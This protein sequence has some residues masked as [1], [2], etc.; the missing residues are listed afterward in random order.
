MRWCFALAY[1]CAAMV[2]GMPAAADEPNLERGLAITDTDVLERLERRGLALDVFLKSDWQNGVEVVPASNAVLANMA[3]LKHVFAAVRREIL[4]TKNA[5]P[6]SGVGMSFDHKRLFDSGYLAAADARFPL[7]GIVQ[8]LD[9]TYKQP[10]TCGEVRLIYRLEYMRQTTQGL[11]RSRLPM[12]FNLVMKA[13]GTEDQISCSSL[14]K[15]WLAAGDKTTRGKALADYLLSSEGP[16]SLV[17]PRLIDRIETNFQ[18]LRRPATSVSQFGGHAEYVLKVFDWYPDS[19]HFRE[20]AM[21]NMIDRDRLIADPALLAAFKSWLLTP[22]KMREL[23][24]RNNRHSARLSGD[25]RNLSS[26]R[27]ACTVG[28]PALLRSLAAGRN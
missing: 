12:T 8:R 7:V 3:E 16:L 28:Q 6:E 13:K 22:E 21:E 2:G 18:A 26:A 11:A 1:V 10:A 25:F 24:C 20:T 17:S 15:R 9:R 23:R 14:A 19:R 4:L 27:R 5:N